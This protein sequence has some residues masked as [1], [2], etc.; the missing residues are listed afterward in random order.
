M[1]LVISHPP[2]PNF[3]DAVKAEYSIS[4]V[5]VFGDAVS[6]LHTNQEIQRTWDSKTLFKYSRKTAPYV[7]RRKILVDITPSLRLPCA[8][9]HLPLTYRSLESSPSGMW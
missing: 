5:Q 8:F 9:V 7:L 2:S 1:M 6:L 3:C 4:T